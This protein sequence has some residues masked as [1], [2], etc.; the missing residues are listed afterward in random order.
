MFPPSQM[1]QSGI[2]PQRAPF[3]ISWPLASQEVNPVQHPIAFFTMTFISTEG[4]R[5]WH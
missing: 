1:L 3:W 4:H 2:W 5:R